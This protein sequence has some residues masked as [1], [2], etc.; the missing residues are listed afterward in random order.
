MTSTLPDFSANTAAAAPGSN[1]ISPAE[2]NSAAATAADCGGDFADLLPP[3]AADNPAEIVGQA[4]AI[5]PSILA[6]CVPAAGETGGTEAATA[7]PADAA[8]PVSRDTLEAAA[9]FA[10]TLMQALVPEVTVPAALE[11]MRSGAPSAANAISEPARRDAGG[12]NP[13]LA[14]AESVDAAPGEAGAGELRVAHAADSAVE[15]K[16][17][18]P[19]TKTTGETAGKAGMAFEVRAQLEL[20]GQAVTRFEARGSL[21]AEDGAQTG[22]A[23][24][25]AKMSR[26]KAASPAG[27]TAGEINF[28]FTGDKQVKPRSPESGITVA[29]TDPIMPAAPIEEVQTA[30]SAEQSSAM[31]VRPDFQVMPTP[32]ERITA[33]AEASAGQN[34]AERAVATVTGLVDAQFSASMQKSGSVQLRLKFGGEDLSV[35]VELRGG[36]VHTD[37]RTDSAELRAALTREMQ[38]VASQSP[39]QMRRYVAPVFSPADTSSF[40]G[41][42][43]QQPGRQQQAAQQDLPQRAPRALF[44]EVAPFAGRSLLRDTFFPEPVAARAPVLLP[45]SLRLSAL[46]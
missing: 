30:R 8:P 9:A 32:A 31:P 2:R 20:P 22:Q 42:S 37:F 13:Q 16:L 23:I 29:K 24:F 43:Q 1:A 14:S 45:T 26:A 44:D 39:E 33:P 25:A 41:H 18:L 5:A 40:S 36:A 12:P 21:S 15:I 28:V 46:A 17:D 7:A 6:L 10:A 34:F 35:R 38:A 11:G 19:E 3:P 4:T 27:K